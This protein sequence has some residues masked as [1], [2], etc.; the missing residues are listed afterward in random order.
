[1]NICIK[2]G[3]CFIEGRVDKQTCRL[4]VLAYNRAYYKANRQKVIAAS[5]A[6]AKT[7][8]GKERMRR[9]RRTDAGRAFN[10]RKGKSKRLRARQ[11]PTRYPNMLLSRIRKRCKKSGILFNLTPGDLII[12]PTCPI[13]GFVFTRGASSGTDVTVDRIKPCLGYTKGNIVVVSRLANQIKSSATS[14][15]VRAVADFY[16]RLSSHRVL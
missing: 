12:P 15:Q 8:E 4:C 14:E 3:E 10:N 7:P 6:R 2:C 16:E 5:K 13:F 11:D 9:W 1:M